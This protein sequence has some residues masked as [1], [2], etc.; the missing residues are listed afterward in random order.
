[1][2]SHDPIKPDAPVT[3]TDSL[4]DPMLISYNII[5]NVAKYDVA[6]TASI[7]TLEYI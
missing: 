6:M 7:G 3:Q 4:S 2:T 5:M 1:M